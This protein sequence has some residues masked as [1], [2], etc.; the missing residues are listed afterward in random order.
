MTTP[1]LQGLLVDR[2]GRPIPQYFNHRTGL[3]EALFG[4]GGANFSNL[5]R[6]WR[7][8]FPG[9]ALAAENWQTPVVGA[10]QII[11]VTAS[12]LRIETG[13]TIN[14]NTIITSSPIF[15][16]PCRVQFTY[17][18]SQRIANQRFFLEL[19]NAAGVMRA[20]FELTGT[21]ATSGNIE[22]M[23][24]GVLSSLAGM[25]IQSSAVLAHLEIEIMQDAVYFH[26]QAINN[27]GARAG[28]LVRTRLLPDPN[29]SY[30]VR[31]RSENLG[32]APASSTTLTVDSI[33]VEDL[34]TLAV[35]LLGGQGNAALA[36]SLGVNVLG[37]VLGTLSTITTLATMTTG[38]I[39]SINAVFLDSTAILGAN[40][41][42]NGISRDFTATQRVNR[43]RA[44]SFA[45]VA[46]TLFVEQS[47]NGTNWITTHRVE[48]VSVAD[49]DAVSRFIATIDAPVMA[50]FARVRYR[51]GATVQT[52]FRLISMQCGI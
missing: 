15:K 13:V 32:V 14:S 29:E 43:F 45:D 47:D 11:T 17:S 34:S 12:E 20:S 5:R 38:N 51:N 26:Q 36:Q 37:G 31:I 2:D 48:A 3:Y 30:H 24:G 19:V 46:G 39:Q 50:R 40:V 7:E 35:E 21:T 10:G 33:L 28:T 22:T 49:A 27:A 25:T 6:V 44:A 4:D 1:S 23:N 8:D 9:T 41:A 16:T 18:L 42:F 52:M